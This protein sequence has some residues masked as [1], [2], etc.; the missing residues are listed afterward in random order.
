VRQT[1]HGASCRA[2]GHHASQPGPVKIEAA[3]SAKHVEKLSAQEQAG[4]Q[5]ALQGGTF[6]VIESATAARHLRLGVAFMAVTRQGVPHQLLH[7]DLGLLLP[8][9]GYLMVRQGLDC[10]N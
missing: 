5:P 7:Q 6:D 3:D 9:L 8:Q 10:V 1:L 2:P 4:P